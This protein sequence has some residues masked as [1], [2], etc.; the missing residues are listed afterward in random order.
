[1]NNGKHG[2]GTC[3]TTMGADS[4]AE[5]TL[6]ASKHFSLK[7]LLK[8]KSSRFLKKSSLWVSVVRDQIHKAMIVCTG[9]QNFDETQAV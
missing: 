4:L 8:P 2:Q 1:M 3:S 5:N 6:N 7:C 9:L